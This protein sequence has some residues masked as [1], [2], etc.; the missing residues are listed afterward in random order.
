LG[1]NKGIITGTTANALKTNTV[2]QWSEVLQWKVPRGYFTQFLTASGINIYLPTAVTVS[3]TGGGDETFSL[4]SSAPIVDSASRTDDLTAKAYS[5]DN[6]VIAV[7]SIDYTNNEVVINHDTAEDLDI[8]YLAS[9]G[10]VRI[11]IYRPSSGVQSFNLFEK[12]ITTLHVMEQDNTDSLLTLDDPFP[13]PEK[14]LLKLEVNAPYQI[15]WKEG[16]S[17]NI[18]HVAIPFKKQDVRR[19]SQSDIEKI[20]TLFVSK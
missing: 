16:V 13:A 20:N 5:D 6:T 14:Y 18:A 1:R 3:H 11:N 12:A 17:D 2:N 4:N 9:G 10:A 15:E 8:V 7:K 19:L